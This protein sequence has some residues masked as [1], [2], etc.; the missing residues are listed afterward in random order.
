MAPGPTDLVL[1]AWF[2]LS[3][4]GWDA[5]RG[6]L[7]SP[8]DGPCAAPSDLVGAVLPAETAELL[9]SDRLPGPCYPA[10]PFENIFWTGGGVARLPGGILLTTFSR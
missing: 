7:G 5:L 10:T 2:P 1:V 9:S 8:S 3:D 4:D 6:S